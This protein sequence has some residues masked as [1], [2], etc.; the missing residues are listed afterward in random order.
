MDAFKDVFDRYALSFVGG[1]MGGGLMTVRSDFK[2]AKQVANMTASD[3]YQML[4]HI[5]D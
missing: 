3:A 5:V 2:E 1:A 4:V